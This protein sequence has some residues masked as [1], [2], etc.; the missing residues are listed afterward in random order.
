M[1]QFPCYSSGHTSFYPPGGSGRTWPGVCRVWLRVVWYKSGSDSWWHQCGCSRVFLEWWP[2]LLSDF[3]RHFGPRSCG[4]S[5][6]NF[7][8]LM[9]SRRFWRQKFPMSSFSLS[10]MTQIS[11]A[12][13]D[14][15][16]PWP[17]MLI[18]RAVYQHR[19]GE[20]SEGREQRVACHTSQ[21]PLAH[22]S[23]SVAAWQS[24]WCSAT[25]ARQQLCPME[26][27]L[28]PFCCCPPGVPGDGKHRF[29][30]WPAL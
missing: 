11:C 8:Q 17:S 26:L 28:N 19:A 10:S 6:L 24:T 20:F 15:A 16:E 25:T 29:Q 3:R 18:S 27:W 23:V 2:I 13:P 30:V 14:T 4:F 1:S 9:G 22:V 21:L 7:E 5:T 12:G